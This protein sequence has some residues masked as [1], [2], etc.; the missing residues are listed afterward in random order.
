MALTGAPPA[1][2]VSAGGG[3]VGDRLLPTAVAAR[4][5]SGLAAEP[6]LVIGGQNLPATELAALARQAG[7]ALELVRYRPDLPAL[8]AGS[9]GLGLAGR[10]PSCSG[11]EPGA[12]M[13]LVLFAAGGE[14]EQTRRAARLKPGWAWPSWCPRPA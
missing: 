12:R 5:L 4:P 9:N 1:V 3:A 8:M 14:D 2:V 7:P 6:R 10:L 11:A 13:V